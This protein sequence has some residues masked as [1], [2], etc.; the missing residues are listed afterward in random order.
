MASH[1]L[2]FSGQH[3]HLHRVFSDRDKRQ[4]TQEIRKV[5]YHNSSHRE[6]RESV[7]I[8]SE[9]LLRSFLFPT[10][11]ESDMLPLELLYQ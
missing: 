11:P 3:W 10:T 5:G 2:K 9:Q 6:K 1:F 4:E 8:Y 7:R